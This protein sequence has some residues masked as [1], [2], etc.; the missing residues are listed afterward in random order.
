MK[1][2]SPN[3]SCLHRKVRVQSSPSD[4]VFVTI[5]KIIQ[6]RFPKESPVNATVLRRGTGHHVLNREDQGGRDFCFCFQAS[7]AA[8]LTQSNF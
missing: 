6:C 3:I 1:E 2:A 4:K 8:I 5:D 7:Q